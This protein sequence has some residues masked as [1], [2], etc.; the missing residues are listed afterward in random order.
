MLFADWRLM[1]TGPADCYTNMAID[2]ATAVLVSQ[3][4]APP[5]VRFYCWEPPCQTIGYS[6]RL[7]AEVC[8]DLSRRGL[9]CVRRLTG[10][11]ACLHG[12]DLSYSLIVSV[13][14]FVMPASV[15]GSFRRIASG[16]IEGLRLL[17]IDARFLPPADIETGGQRIATAAQARLQGVLV[18]QGSI[19]LAPCVAAEGSLLPSYPLTPLSDLVGEELGPDVVIQAMSM[20]LRSALG[21]DLSPSVLLAK[22]KR[23][24]RQLLREKY[25]QSEWTFFREP[26]RL[27]GT[28]SRRHKTSIMEEEQ[29]W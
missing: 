20:G 19:C 29:K 17:G 27:A 3:Q 1:S 24:A 7:G 13:R 5:T 6:Q 2:E 26:R 12:G 16:I 15:P 4:R 21:I 9:R 25:V 23:L 18:H 11:A 22:E 14:D 10:G 28:L 8:P